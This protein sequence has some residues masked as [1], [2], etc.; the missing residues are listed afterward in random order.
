[1]TFDGLLWEMS[2]QRISWRY[3]GNCRTVLG[4][5]GCVNRLLTVPLSHPAA[6]LNGM[7]LL[8]KRKHKDTLEG[9]VPLKMYIDVRYTVFILLF[10]TSHIVTFMFWHCWSAITVIA[11]RLHKNST[12]MENI[13]NYLKI[14][15]CNQATN[16][17]VHVE[18]TDINEM[19]IHTYITL[20]LLN[21]GKASYK[22]I[23]RE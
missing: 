4:T 9:T 14:I 22:N 11:H 18:Y 3:E 16:N 1:V 23:H 20:K 12:N 6:V 19:H 5:V 17:D 21:S 15:F 10:S 13:K 8:P 2:T 7:A